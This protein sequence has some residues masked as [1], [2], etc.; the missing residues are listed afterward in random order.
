MRAVSAALEF[1]L[2]EDFVLLISQLIFF[3]YICK[4]L[5]VTNNG[6]FAYID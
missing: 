3:A 5:F 6:F 1:V 4:L 2:V